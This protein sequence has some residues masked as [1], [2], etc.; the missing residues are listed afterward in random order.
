[1]RFFSYIGE[2]K[3]SAPS[4]KIDII[5]RSVQDASFAFA[6]MSFRQFIA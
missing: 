4:R 2:L 1:M 5:W 3:E 6:R